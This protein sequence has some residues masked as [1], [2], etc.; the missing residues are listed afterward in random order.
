L[1]ASVA[2]AETPLASDTKQRLD[3]LTAIYRQGDH[4]R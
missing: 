2:A 3:E 4:D 1:A